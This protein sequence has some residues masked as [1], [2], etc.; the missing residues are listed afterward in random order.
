M[1]RDAGQQPAAPRGSAQVGGQLQG[2]WG[3]GAAAGHE[4]GRSACWWL[5][6]A[7]L[8]LYC[9]RCNSLPDGRVAKPA[10][11]PK[12][13][14]ACSKGGHIGQNAHHVREGQVS[15]LDISGEILLCRTWTA[16]ALCSW[17]AALAARLNAI[18][19][20]TRAA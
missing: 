2:A 7:A 3:G 16:R 20:L 18:T 11:Q 12:G 5:R 13:A 10:R 9:T 4:E 14:A 15:A 6:F 17:A 1:R 19:V 8:S